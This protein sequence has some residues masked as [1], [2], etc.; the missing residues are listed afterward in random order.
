LFIK[1]DFGDDLACETLFW[2]TFHPGD[3]DLAVGTTPEGIV[4]VN[5][6]A[7]ID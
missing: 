6:E 5:Y 4:E 2:F 3:V 7:A 1:F